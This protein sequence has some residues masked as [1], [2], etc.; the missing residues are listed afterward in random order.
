VAD[1]MPGIIADIRDGRRSWFGAAGVADTGTG[2]K[3]RPQDHFRAGSVNKSFTS[4][5]V[6]K[7]AAERRLSLDDTVEKWLPGVVKGNGHD[8]SKITIRQLL[9]HTSGIFPYTLDKRLIADYFTPGFLEHR[10][11]NYRPEQLVQLAMANPADFPPGTGWFYSN[12]NYVLAGMIIEK[13]TSSSYADEVKRLIIRP[14]GLTGTS[15]PGTET[16]LPNPYTRHYSSLWAAEPVTKVYDTTDLNASWAWAV[17]GIVSTAGDLQK[18]YRALLGGHLL[19]PAQQKELLTTVSTDGGG[20]IPNTGYGLGVFSQK[21]SCGVTAWGGGG[22]IH[23]SWTSAM[24]SRDG[25]HMI[26][27]NVNGDWGNQ[28]DT[29]TKVMEAELC[30]PASR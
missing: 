5:V 16:K 11:D 23:G 22:M 2:R 18:F 3:R 19:P 9:N 27:T 26:V 1:G 29:L 17:G 6:L 14:L 7:L 20:W 28:L 15:L 25:Q 8:G 4:A 24:G 21:L 13:V 10:F 30:P 12:T